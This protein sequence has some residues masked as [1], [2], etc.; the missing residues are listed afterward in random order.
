M[1]EF[2]IVLSDIEKALSQINRDKLDILV[3]KIVNAHHIF[4]A[5]AGRSGLMLRAFAN[6]L[7]HLGLS[8]SVV[9]DTNSPHTQINDLLIIAS[10][11]GK[12]TS[13]I[14]LVKKAHSLSLDSA[15][16]TASRSTTIGEFSNLVLEIPAQNKDDE[17][18]SAQP[19]GSA[20]EQCSLVLY[21]TLI[22]LLMAALNESSET[23]AKRHADLE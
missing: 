18:K 8:A 15:L 16:I 22:L 10:G 2:Q 6:R 11:S 7:M 19:M 21:D 17:S 9:G 12:T 13:L 14:S 3:S 20:F 1:E 23:M 5:G 4:L